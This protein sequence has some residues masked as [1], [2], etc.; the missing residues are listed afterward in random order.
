LKTPREVFIVWSLEQNIS[1][2]QQAMTLGYQGWEGA[3]KDKNGNYIISTVGFLIEIYK[4]NLDSHFGYKKW[5]DGIGASKKPPK[6]GSE[7]SLV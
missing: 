2:K 7:H 5:S 1:L 3:P 6:S 4:P